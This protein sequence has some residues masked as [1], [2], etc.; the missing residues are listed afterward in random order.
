MIILD[1]S[2]LKV[3]EMYYDSIKAGIDSVISDNG[4]K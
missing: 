1:K 2:I 4:T 3:N